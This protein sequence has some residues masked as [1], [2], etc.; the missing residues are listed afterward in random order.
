MVGVVSGMIVAADDA[1]KCFAKY[2]PEDFGASAGRNVEEHGTVSDK[3]PEIAPAT[4]VFPA[5]FVDVEQG[6]G[7]DITL[8][9][10]E[11]RATGF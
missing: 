6:R 4:L 9:G 5:G 11:D 10:P 2:F 8:D 7:G 3:A 1:G